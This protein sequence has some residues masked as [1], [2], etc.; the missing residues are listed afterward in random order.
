MEFASYLAGEKWSDHPACTHPLLAAMARHVNDCTTNTGRQQ[1]VELV[2]SVIGLTSD[3]PH[4]DVRIALRAA[5]TALPVAAAD[6]VMAVAVL[7]CRQVLA[8]LD[9]RPAWLDEESRAALD[10]VPY[11]ADWAR[12]HLRGT[13][14]SLRTFRR[15]TAP[16]AVR[17]AVVGIARAT[18]V[19]SDRLLRD[20]L[21]T[22]I[23]DCRELVSA[24]PQV[25]QLIGPSALG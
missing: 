8:D 4:V 15:H 12:R 24:A 10:Q 16:T 9:G 22:A 19:D 18:E 3:D 1:L 14:V 20:L 13:T 5:T 11:A 2:P 21:A 6:R 23:A 25:V 7:I 17:D